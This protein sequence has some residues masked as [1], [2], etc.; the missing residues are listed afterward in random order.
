MYYH[1]AVQST[2]L[3]KKIKFTWMP[4]RADHKS[5]VTVLIL[6]RKNKNNTD[7]SNYSLFPKSQDF[8]FSLLSN[9]TSPP[10]NRIC[11]LKEHGQVGGFRRDHVSTLTFIFKVYLFPEYCFTGKTNWKSVKDFIPFYFLAT[12]SGLGVLEV[13]S[14][15]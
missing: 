10:P 2:K 6:S 12:K 1:S 13:D 4:K 9:A 14:H 5:V 15:I 3:N 7:C 8:K 11:V